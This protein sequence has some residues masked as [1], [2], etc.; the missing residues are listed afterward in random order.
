MLKKLKQKAKDKGRRYANK[1]L[2]PSSSERLV[3][4]SSTVSVN[5]TGVI[6]TPMPIPA[7]PEPASD[8][9]AL[10]PPGSSPQVALGS[11]PQLV[12]T[13]SVVPSSGAPPRTSQ[14]NRS[15]SPTLQGTVPVE[16]ASASAASRGDGRSA[17]DTA[18]SGL[19]T[20]LD[21]L[22]ASAD[23][24]G[25]LKSAVGGISECINIY[26]VRARVSVI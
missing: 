2:G 20:L 8:L 23:A 14:P 13:S 10:T 5:E 6:N 15:N 11:V 12:V 19:K 17:N 24:F 4:Q 26:E 22:N 16:A 3:G 1:L 25:P 21:L 18:W 9:I 7:T